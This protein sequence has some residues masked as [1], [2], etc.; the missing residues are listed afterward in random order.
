[1]KFVAWVGRLGFEPDSPPR[2]QVH[3]RTAFYTRRLPRPLKANVLRLWGSPRLLQSDCLTGL[4]VHVR[5]DIVA[6][7]LRSSRDGLE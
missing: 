6:G 2:T 3:D 7:E 4:C 5:D 1:M